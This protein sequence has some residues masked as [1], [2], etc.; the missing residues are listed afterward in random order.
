MHRLCQYR[1][2]T[3]FSSGNA[4]KSGKASGRSGQ[5]QANGPGYLKWAD[6]NPEG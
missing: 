3:L 1:G 5:G 4:P 2:K 6:S